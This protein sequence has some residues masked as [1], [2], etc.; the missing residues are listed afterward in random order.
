MLHGS[1]RPTDRKRESAAEA[2]AIR[3]YLQKERPEEG[4]YTILAP[5]HMQIERLK[6]LMPGERGNILTVH[7]A[8]GMEWD[9][10]ILSV[11]DTKDAY[12][13]NSGLTIGKCVLNTAISRAKKRLVIVC[14]TDFWGSERK[15][16]ISELIA[17]STREA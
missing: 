11:C 13:V 5:Y 9:T 14:D 2:L 10:V 3:D 1:K 17:Q 16:L 12:F 6:K 15:Q 7:R 4:S 8:Q